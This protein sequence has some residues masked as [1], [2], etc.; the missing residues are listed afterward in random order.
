M[1]KDLYQLQENIESQW[2]ELTQKR[3]SAIEYSE[4]YIDI[5]ENYEDQIVTGSDLFWQ[6]LASGALSGLGVGSSLW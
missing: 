2:T 5:A 3:T 4:S 1:S 6:S